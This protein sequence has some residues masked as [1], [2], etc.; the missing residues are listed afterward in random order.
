MTD[1]MKI[2]IGTFTLILVILFVLGAF[3]IINLSKN[4]NLDMTTYSARKEELLLE[5]QKLQNMITELNSTLKAEAEANQKL[6]QRLALID[7]QLSSISNQT[8]TVSSAPQQTAQT[9]PPPAPIPQA[10]TVRKI[11]RAS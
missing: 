5:Q 7:S 6:T 3:Y 9:T 8:A 4:T 11:T 1:L 10:P 2:I